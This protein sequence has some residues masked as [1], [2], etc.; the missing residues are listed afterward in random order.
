MSEFPEELEVE[1]TSPKSGKITEINFV[2]AA[3]SLQNPSAKLKLVCDT[4]LQIKIKKIT[5]CLF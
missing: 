2:F 5:G 1:H 4:A 3:H